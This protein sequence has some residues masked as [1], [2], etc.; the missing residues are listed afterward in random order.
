MAFEAQRQ[1]YRGKTYWVIKDPAGM[2][3]FRFQE[4]EYAI[5]QMLDSQMSL[6]KVKDQFEAQFSPQKITLEELQQ[7]LGLLHR[8]GLAVASVRRGKGRN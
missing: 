1:C 7:F 6:D 4:E 3:Y 2:H 5:L 8:S